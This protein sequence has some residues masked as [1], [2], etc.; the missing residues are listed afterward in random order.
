MDKRIRF[1]C[2]LLLAGSLA[3]VPGAS[4]GPEIVLGT[5]ATDTG[6]GSNDAVLADQVIEA[7][8]AQ[9]AAHGL[10]A[11]V[12]NDKLTAAALGHATLMAEKGF[13]SH[14]DPETGSMPWDRATAAGYSYVMIAENLA[15]GF[16]TVDLVVNGWMNSPDHR[17][18]ILLPLITETGVAIYRGGP[19][20]IYWVQL[21][22]APQQ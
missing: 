14:Q 7:V 11:L 2:L 15:A 13:F 16:P 19:V 9:R 3:L 4:C 1:A 12:K 18:N 17:F 21:F 22:G 10:P 6:D 8:N 5:Q 20:G